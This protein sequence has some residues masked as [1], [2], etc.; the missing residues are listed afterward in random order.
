MLPRGTVEWARFYPGCGLRQ[1]G[2]LLMV[3]LA[4]ARMPNV[5]N[6]M[7]LLR[8]WVRMI[9]DPTRRAARLSMDCLLTLIVIRTYCGPGRIVLGSNHGH[10]AQHSVAVARS[11][12]HTPCEL[13]WHGWAVTRSSRVM[14]ASANAM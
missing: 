2:M 9:G 5:R 8:L 4:P 10:A 14:G 6:R 3:M 12:D 13:A 11:D 7:L 1:R